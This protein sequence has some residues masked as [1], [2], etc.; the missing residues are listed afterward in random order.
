METRIL[1]TFRSHGWLFLCHNSVNRVLVCIDRMASASFGRP[2]AIQD[3]E[4][5]IVSRVNTIQLTDGTRHSFDI[6]L[7]VDCDDEYWEHPD[8]A[9]RFKQPPNKPSSAIS[10]IIYIKILQIL[11]LSLRTIVRFMSFLPTVTMI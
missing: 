11:G 9:Q 4:Y 3:E 10:F 1:V 7:P 2:S 6:D 5:A 8:P